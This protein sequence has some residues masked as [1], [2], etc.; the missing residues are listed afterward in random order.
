M[1]K[2][3]SKSINRRDFLKRTSAGAAS[4]P[5][6]LNGMPMHAFDGP[7]LQR[8][9]NTAEG[10]DRVLVLVQL[11]GGNDG[12][13]TVVPLDQLQTY[14]DLRPGVAIPENDTFQ[15]APDAGL[16]PSFKEIHELYEEQKVGIV[17]GVN[18]P[19]PNQSHFRSNDIWMS[20]SAS[21]VSLGSGWMGRY[22]DTV[23]PGFPE[24]YPNEAM[25]DPVAIQM[26]AVVGLSLVGPGGRS[27]GMAL[28]ISTPPNALAF[29]T[30]SFQTGQMAKPG[31]IIALIGLIL[32][33]VLM[34]VLNLIGFF[35]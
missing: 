17:Q 31:V 30:G 4:L 12:L 32:N 22:L 3:Q 20:G 11:N 6:I 29:A 16:H 7:K 26:S 9:F 5:I 21:D 2:K 14:N 23:Y 15:I 18:Y 24:G 8:L 19:N 35:G 25:P 10:S 33:Y 1:K 34:A 28:P 13:N 27:M